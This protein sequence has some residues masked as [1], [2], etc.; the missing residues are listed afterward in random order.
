MS[1]ADRKRL[2]QAQAQRSAARQAVYAA[3]WQNDAGYRRMRGTQA[4]YNRQLSILGAV[5]RDSAEYR[6]AERRFHAASRRVQ[7]REDSA[8]LRA[9]L[10][11]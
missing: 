1:K 8:L 10:K 7:Q 9:G 6:Q 3:L 5:S 11:P 2:E 4:H